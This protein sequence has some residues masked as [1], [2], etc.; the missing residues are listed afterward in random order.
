[1]RSPLRVMR[2]LQ[3]WCCRVFRFISSPHMFTCSAFFETCMSL[4]LAVKKMLSTF[5]T[6]FHMYRRY[7]VVLW[8]KIDGIVFGGLGE[9]RPQ[10][11]SPG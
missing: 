1:M 10:S 7:S 8:E 5:A 4:N 9:G 3:H 2:R 11:C 6:H